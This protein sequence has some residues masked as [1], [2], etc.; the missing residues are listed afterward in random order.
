VVVAMTAGAAMVGSAFGPT[1]PF[2]AGIALK[3]AQLPPFAAVG[4]RAAMFAAGLALWI[5]W[6]VRHAVRNRDAIAPTTVPQASRSTSTD[7]AARST[8]VLTPATHALIL[9]LLLVPMAVYVYGAV[10]L[11]WGFNELSGAFLIGGTLA[12][13]VG[14]LGAA[15]TLAAY[16]A[17]A[18][19]LLSA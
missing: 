5:A 7:G 1:N 18:E 19:S 11:D 17:G 9:A 6:I 4:M 10:K 12:G 8:R 16:L 2:Q 13:L 3:L 15:G 14:G